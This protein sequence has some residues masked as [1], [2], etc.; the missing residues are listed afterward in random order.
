MLSFFSFFSFLTDAPDLASVELVR[1][2]ASSPSLSF[3]FAHYFY[4]IH[5]LDYT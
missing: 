2:R 1:A 5:I 3:L 4:S